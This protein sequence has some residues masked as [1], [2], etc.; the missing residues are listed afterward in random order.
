MNYDPREVSNLV[1]DALLFKQQA[2]AQRPETLT[3]E[4]EAEAKASLRTV[5]DLIDAM[6]RQRRLWVANGM[7]AL[8]ADESAPMPGTFS[9]ARWREIQEAFTGLEQWM[10]AP[11]A[12]GA[13]PLVVVSRRGNPPET[14]TIPGDEGGQE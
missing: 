6:A 2:E 4:L 8:L 10:L 9:R 13:P 14:A 3:E 1:R 5:Q 12:G 7:D 11:L